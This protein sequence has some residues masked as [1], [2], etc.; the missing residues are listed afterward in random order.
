MR[1][2]AKSSTNSWHKPRV[3][4]GSESLVPEVE[5]EHAKMPKRA[6]EKP[7]Q[8]PTRRQETTRRR[9]TDSR[10]THSA[11]EPNSASFNAQMTNIRWDSNDHRALRPRLDPTAQPRDFEPTHTR[12]REF[13]RL[14]KLEPFVR[15]RV[16]GTLQRV[17][18]QICRN[19]SVVELH[20]QHAQTPTNARISPQIERIRIREHGFQLACPKAQNDC[21]EHCKDLCYNL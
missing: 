14:K 6:P 12:S 13:V 8:M 15:G 11:R 2:R 9:R 1:T 17:H 18:Q 3:F 21:L 19:H 10:T 4:F 7:F 16:H 5:V 20:E